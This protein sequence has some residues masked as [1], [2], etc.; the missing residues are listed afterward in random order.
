VSPEREFTVT[1]AEEGERLDRFLAARCPDHSRNQIQNALREGRVTVGGRVRPK[2][3]RLSAGERVGFDPPPPPVTAVEPQDIP[4]DVVH[5]DDDLIVVNKPPGLVTHPA[6][7]HPD[8]TLVNAL[9]HHL[10]TP[11]PGDDPLRPGIVH[12]LDRDTSG[13]IVVA[14]S[15]RALRALADQIRE[16]RLGRVYLA[17]A[18]GRWSEPEGVLTGAVGRHPRDRQRMAVVTRGGREAVT[19]YRVVEDFDFV[20]LCRVRLETGRTHQIRVHFAHHGHPVVGD[21]VYGDDRRA[22]NVRPV[23]RAR[24][25][26]LVR[27]AGRQLLHAAELE[28]DHPASG[29]RVRFAAPLPRDLAAALSLLRPA[30]APQ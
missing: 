15:E 23:D 17:L 27:L 28:L 3:F 9:L 12:R 29:E 30:A 21:P 24:A 14:R 11:G 18:W 26:G 13:L 2:G 7:G 19:R 25:A 8:G 6:P 10:A 16:R 4:L 20:Q 5:E 1:A 22:R